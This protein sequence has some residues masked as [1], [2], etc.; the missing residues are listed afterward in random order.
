MTALNLPR[1]VVTK[2]GACRPI[3]KNG[4]PYSAPN[5]VDSVADSVVDAPND[6]NSLAAGSIDAPNDINAKAAIE[7]DAPNVISTVAQSFNP[8]F[9]LKNPRILYETVT[10]GAS[11]SATSGTNPAYALTPNT[12][13]RWIFS[14]SQSITITFN[15]DKLI[16]SVG[17]GS[18]Q[19][20]GKTVFVEYST[21]STSAFLPMQTQSGKDGAMLFLT[22]GYTGH[23]GYTARRVR[24]R[25]IGSGTGSIGVIYAGVA[26][27]LQ[28]AVYGGVSPIP[29]SR[30]T[31]YSNSRT[32]SGEWIG[33]SIKS[34][35]YTGQLKFDKLFADW[36][37]EYFDPFVVAAIEKPFF[38]SWRPDEYPED[39][40]YCWT[41]GDIKP[42]N[43][44]GGGTRVSVSFSVEA[45]G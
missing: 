14:G 21:T 28:Q 43:N 4:L 25:T 19:L 27:Q 35:G 5:E 29:L 44:G 26:L 20:S 7:A 24:I 41:T 33:R 31:Q 17:I 11:I 40:V 16:D 15:E 1:A 45:H 34:Q 37:R 9:P 2:R 13:E 22:N 39:A 23:Q 3:P 6:V 42:S 10:T 12:W 36:Y 30:V 18:A 38:F 32:E 8:P